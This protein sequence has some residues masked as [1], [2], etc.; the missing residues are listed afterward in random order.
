MGPKNQFSRGATQL[1]QANVR[2][3][4]STAEDIVCDGCGNYTFIPVIMMKRV[5][6]LES[7]TGKEAAV[8]VET[9][10][11]NACGYVNAQFMPKFAQDSGI[12]S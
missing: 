10:A 6:P 7:P 8:P 1:P 4:L 12:E 3:D 9:F 2:I 11:C 5:S